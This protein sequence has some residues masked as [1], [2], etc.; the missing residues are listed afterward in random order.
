MGDSEER[1]W[2]VVCETYEG[3]RRAAGRLGWLSR[4]LDLERRTRAGERTLEAWESL[5]RDIAVE[6]EAED[7]GGMRHDPLTGQRA[8][9]CPDSRCSRAVR[10]RVEQ[11]PCRLFGVDMGEPRE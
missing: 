5:C 10:P 1:R 11:P 4:F 9:R 8:H 3:T 7:L 6:A 2:A